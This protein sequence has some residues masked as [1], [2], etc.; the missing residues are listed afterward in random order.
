[1]IHGGRLALKSKM[2]LNFST[3]RGKS[4]LLLLSPNK[5]ED[6][7][8]A[9]GEF[10]HRCS[11]EHYVSMLI[12]AR[13]SIHHLPFAKEMALHGSHFASSKVEQIDRSAKR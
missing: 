9:R 5:I 1:M 2:G 3:R 7:L 11:A 13:K 8:L 6:L 12:L 4:S 10:S